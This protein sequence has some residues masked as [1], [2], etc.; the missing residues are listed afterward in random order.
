M[1]P[2]LFNFAGWIIT[3]IIFSLNAPFKTSEYIFLCL[4]GFAFSS[5][6]TWFFIG[7]TSPLNEVLQREEIT[8]T[9]EWRL[10]LYKLALSDYPAMDSNEGFCRYFWIVAD[11]HITDHIVFRYYFPELYSLATFTP[12]TH[13]LWW[14]NNQDRIQ[15]L[16]MAIS[17]VEAQLLDKSRRNPAT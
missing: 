3:C 16:T 17:M 6:I 1:K 12:A 14:E 4:A 10:R 15:A 7:K 8:G 5:L 2:F 9:P 13:K 11:V